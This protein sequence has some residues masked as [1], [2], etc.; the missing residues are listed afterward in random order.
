[1]AR[2]TEEAMRAGAVGFS[3]SRTVGHRSVTGNEVPGT[4][5]EADELLA[6]GDVLA[7]VGYGLFEGAMRLG[8]RDDDE[9]TKTREELALMGEISRRSGRPLAR[10]VRTQSRCSVS[11]TVARVIR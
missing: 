8:E 11:S 3:T 6:F 7:K 10:A 5:A 9:L 4:F 1:M 2:L